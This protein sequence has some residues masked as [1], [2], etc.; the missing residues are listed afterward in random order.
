[1]GPEASP[2]SLQLRCAPSCRRLSLQ[3]RRPSRA[4]PPPLPPAA[5]R[6]ARAFLGTNAQACPQRASGR[7]FSASCGELCQELP[8]RAAGCH[9]DLT[10]NCFSVPAKGTYQQYRMPAQASA[11]A[12]CWRWG[13]HAHSRSAGTGARNR[14]LPSHDPRGAALDPAPVSCL[15]RCQWEEPPSASQGARCCCFASCPS[16]P[17]RKAAPRHQD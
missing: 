8:Q 12:A 16:W 1:M 5:T 9:G 6:N 3:A 2:L 15:A 17:R 13:M 10:A 11:K 7:H 4:T 14:S